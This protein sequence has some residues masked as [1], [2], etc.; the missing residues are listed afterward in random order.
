[1]Q[2]SSWHWCAADNVCS[3]ERCAKIVRFEVHAPEAEI[4]KLRG[5]LAS[6]NPQVFALEEGIRRS[7]DA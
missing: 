6:R 3:N 2:A 1:L 7:S 5:P 4:D